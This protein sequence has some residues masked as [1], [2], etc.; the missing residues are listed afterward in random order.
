MEYLT[1]QIPITQFENIESNLNIIVNNNVSN[2]SIINLILS[3]FDEN[4]KL[5][6]FHTNNIEIE[7]V[8]NLSNTLN[9]LTLFIPQSQ[10][11]NLITDL[12]NINIKIKENKDLIDK[13]LSYFD[14]NYKLK[15]INMSNISID[16]II[17]LNPRLLNLQN[18]F[19]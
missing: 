19:I 14:I 11:I 15:L 3:Y 4:N 12:Q 13:I 10:I 5:K 7:N 2:A 1:E 8:N 16:K 18:K 9:N 6:K 17:N